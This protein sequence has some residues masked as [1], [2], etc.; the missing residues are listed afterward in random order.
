MAL[1]RRDRLVIEKFV[2][3]WLAG[4]DVARRFDRPR[5]RSVE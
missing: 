2:H 1:A 5:W 3:V 4:H